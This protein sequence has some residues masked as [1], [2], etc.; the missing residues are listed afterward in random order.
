LDPNI[1]ADYT[2]NWGITLK[3]QGVIKDQ[4]NS[5]TAKEL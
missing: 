1:A 4:M 5:M 3:Y 2:F